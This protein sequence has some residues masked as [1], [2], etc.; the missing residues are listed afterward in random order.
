VPVICSSDSDELDSGI[1]EE[2]AA[3]TPAHSHLQ[4]TDDMEDE[5]LP[6]E[7]CGV[8]HSCLQVN[9]DTADEC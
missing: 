4:T 9:D 6:E 7:T 8:T 2:T 5:A 3:V 1:E